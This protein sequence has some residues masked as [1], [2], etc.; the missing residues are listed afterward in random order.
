MHLSLVTDDILLPFEGLLTSIAGEQPI[1][2]V[3]VLFVDLQVTLVSEGLLAGQ[4]A[5]YDIC[6][7]SVV[8][9]AR[10]IAKPE[11]SVYIYWLR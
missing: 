11:Y 10:V 5:I 7:H 9:A 2:T 8:G 6:F 4:A 3:D 1:G